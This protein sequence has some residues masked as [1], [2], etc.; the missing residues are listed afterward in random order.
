MMPRSFDIEYVWTN[1]VD[2]DIDGGMMALFVVVLM[3]SLSALVGPCASSSSSSNDD[4]V[5][6]GRYGGGKVPSLLLV[7][8]DGSA[9]GYAK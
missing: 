4:F 3:M 1:K 2:V 7:D 6:R 8:G 9:K 5:P